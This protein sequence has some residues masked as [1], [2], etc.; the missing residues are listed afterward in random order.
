MRSGGKPP[1]PPLQLG[2]S[3][4]LVVLAI[5]IIAVASLAYFGVTTW[6]APGGPQPAG[7]VA[8]AQT[9]STVEPWTETDTSTCQARA[10]KA[11]AEPLPADAMLAQRSV[12]EGFAGLTALVACRMTIKSARFCES[13]EKDKLVAMI[14]D[15]VAKVDMITVGLGVQGAPMAMLGAV[16]GGEVAFGSSV[17]EMQ[18]EETMKFMELHHQK[19]VSALRSLARDGIVAP[20]DFAAFMGMGIPKHITEMFGGIEADRHVCG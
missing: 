9:H 5:T 12:T 14:Q 4:D 18:R 6:F 17:Y 13:K 16:T 15:Y 7:A 1:R 3:L 8:I 20:G 2:G 10:R 11:A 19:I